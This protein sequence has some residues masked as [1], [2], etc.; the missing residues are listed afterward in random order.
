M[1]SAFQ[2]GKNDSADSSK[3]KREEWR[4]LDKKTREEIEL[5]D[6]VFGFDPFSSGT[7]QLGWLFNY[8]AVLFVQRIVSNATAERVVADN[9]KG[10]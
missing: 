9:S 10:S 6:S 1:K 2:L 8:K 3:K 7:E 4:P 5:Q